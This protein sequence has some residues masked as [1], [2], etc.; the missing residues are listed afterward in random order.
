MEQRDPAKLAEKLLESAATQTL[1]SWKVF[2]SAV[3]AIVLLW[4]TSIDPLIPKLNGLWTAM[5]TTHEKFKKLRAYET[6]TAKGNNSG[7]KLE[8]FQESAQQSAK[9]RKK[10]ASKAAIAFAIP[11]VPALSIPT[12]YAATLWCLLISILLGYLYL[13]RLSILS[14]LAKSARIFH[15]LEPNKFPYRP[16]STYSIRW[17]LFPLPGKAGVVLSPEKFRIFL[18]APAQ[19]WREVIFVVLLFF[20]LFLL[21]IRVAMIATASIASLGDGNRFSSHDVTLMAVTFLSLA[22]TAAL[23]GLWL[24]QIQVPDRLPPAVTAFHSGRR[25]VISTLAMIAAAS[26]ATGVGI[27]AGPKAL[28]QWIRTPRFRQ[29]SRPSYVAV[30]L[31]SNLYLNIRSNK[32]HYV[33]VS[34]RDIKHSA[35]KR[36]DSY[37]WGIRTIKG[38][39]PKPKNFTAQG[40]SLAHSSALDWLIALP[41]KRRKALTE[42]VAED[43]FASN[44]SNKAFEVLL[45][46]VKADLKS[47]EMQE[48]P[49]LDF[50]PYYQLAK[51]ALI[52]EQPEPLSDMIAAIEAS[53]LRKE[54][55]T[56]IH[57]WTIPT[58]RWRKRLAYIK[59]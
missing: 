13:A 33:A 11:G 19:N 44:N 50:R 55:S 38:R 56:C 3:I 16:A 17:W 40:S 36:G 4:N 41:E 25:L 9:N 20:T 32:L 6:E 27:W 58:S 30:A 35:V 31:A 8:R 7:K 57:S 22:L 2:A 54:F 45:N 37:L 48:Q 14:Q 52:K 43:L 15:D 59:R 26:L 29:R 28:V 49:F 1:S 46:T 5:V 51:H 47:L 23:L 24:R 12:R 42:K 39:S 53:P 18:H 34:K 21:Q 10:E